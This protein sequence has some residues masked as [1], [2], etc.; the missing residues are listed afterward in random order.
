M[1]DFTGPVVDIMCWFRSSRPADNMQ[2]TESLHKSLE[3]A[4]N[5][6]MANL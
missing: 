1:K 2:T 6:A 3:K 5:S 4:A